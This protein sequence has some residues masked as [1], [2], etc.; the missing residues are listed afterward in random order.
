MGGW[1]QVTTSTGDKGLVPKSYVVFSEEEGAGAGGD[2]TVAAFLKRS[3][4]YE[5]DVVPRW[6]A[7]G[8]LACKAAACLSRQQI[9]HGSISITAA[10]L[11]RQH[12]YHGCSLS[13]ADGDVL[14]A[15]A[16][17]VP[18]PL[19]MCRTHPLPLHPFPL[20]QRARLGRQPLHA[21]PAGLT[22]RAARRAAP[23]RHGPQPPPHLQQRQR[24]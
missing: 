14:H 5:Q 18:L 3:S 16:S 19:S 22:R 1:V 17:T 2:N 8:L 7:A 20:L 13:C 24:H 4:V 21:G 15:C 6:G 12:I 10:N 23:Q 9:Y 11:S